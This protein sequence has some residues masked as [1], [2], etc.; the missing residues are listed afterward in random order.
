MSCE[1]AFLLAK[2]LGMIGLLGMVA[3]STETNPNTPNE[4]TE[5]VD[6]QKQ[7]TIIDSVISAYER[8]YLYPDV[9]GKIKFHLQDRFEKGA[10]ADLTRITDFTDALMQ[11]LQKASGDAHAYVL[12]LDAEGRRLWQTALAS[13]FAKVS[14]VPLRARPGHPD[15][16]IVAAAVSLD[17]LRSLLR[18]ADKVLTQ[19]IA[20]RGGEAPA[21]ADAVSPEGGVEGASGAAAGGQVRGREDVVRLLDRICEYYRAHEPS[22]PVPLLLERAKR[23]AYM[24][25]LSIV[26]DLAP[27]GLTEVNTIRGPVGE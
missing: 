1:Y 18:E 16:R 17:P 8:H 15:L 19:Q 22:S 14:V 24:D 9:A 26:Q 27:S 2:A 3:A 10:Y 25:F 20:R 21:A 11:D 12:A 23:L 4:N 13:D 6:R 5:I 7:A